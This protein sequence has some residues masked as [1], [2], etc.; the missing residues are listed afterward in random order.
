M[1]KE[2]T[3]H[4]REFLLTVKFTDEERE[5][6][7]EEMQLESDNVTISEAIIAE[8]ISALEYDGLRPTVESVH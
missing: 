6:F 2:D 7:L 4:K 5:Q 8:V 1:A 3:L